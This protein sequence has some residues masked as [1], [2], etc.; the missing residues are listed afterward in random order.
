[1]AIIYPDIE[2]VLVAHLSESL[3]NGVRVGTIK[4][5]ADQPQ[6]SNQ[7]VVTVAYAGDKEPSQV[8]KFA[9]VVL[10]IY[11]DTYEDASG[12]ALQAEAALR[13]AIVAGP[14]KFVEIIAGPIRVAEETS[15]QRRSISAEVTVKGTDLP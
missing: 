4:T 14:I 6:P 1:M 10:D 8:L 5:P 2:T 12:L 15:Q 13:N 9:G 11:A 7:V 3:G